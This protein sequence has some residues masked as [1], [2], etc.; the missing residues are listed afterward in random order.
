MYQF[1]DEDCPY[2]TPRLV[3]MPERN[4]CASILQRS[5]MDLSSPISDKPWENR[6]IIL[7]AIRFFKCRHTNPRNKFSFYQC[8]HALELDPEMVYKHA[9]LEQKIRELQKAVRVPPDKKWI[10]IEVD[11]S[12]ELAEAILAKRAHR[13]KVRRE[14]Q[15]KQMKQEHEQNL[16]VTVVEGIAKPAEEPL[17]PMLQESL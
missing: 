8:C 1:D 16:I 13:N 14:C 2:D 17:Q 6:Q 11:D 7:Q 3:D 5:L 15:M 12:P 4:L 9:G 10:R